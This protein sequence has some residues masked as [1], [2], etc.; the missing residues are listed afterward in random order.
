MVTV[1]PPETGP[2]LPATSVAVVLKVWLPLALV[3]EVTEYVPQSWSRSRPGCRP[4]DRV[5]IARDSL[6][7]VN[8]GVVSLV[9]RSLEEEP[10]VAGGGERR[11]RGRRR[12]DRV[13]RDRCG[14]RRRRRG[15]R[16]CPLPGRSSRA[17]R[18]PTRRR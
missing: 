11:H 12:R 17:R 13:D 9:I 6:V 7:P 5:T 15:S 8:V 3:L 14:A 18:P 4:P 10:G 16:R 2:R 1:V